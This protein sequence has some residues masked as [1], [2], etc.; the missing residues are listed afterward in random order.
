MADC[1]NNLF[2]EPLKP[3]DLPKSADLPETAELI[4]NIQLTESAAEPITSHGP[5]AESTE[6]NDLPAEATEATCPSET[7]DQPPIDLPPPIDLCYIRHV[8]FTGIDRTKPPIIIQ[9]LE[10][11]F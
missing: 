3:S 10:K 4:R 8:P 6:L 1:N 5:P 7:A 9:V 2:V 11:V